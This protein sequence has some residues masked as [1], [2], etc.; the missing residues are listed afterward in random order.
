VSEAIARARALVERGRCRG[1]YARNQAGGE[2]LILDDAA[3]LFCPE[4]A[5]FRVLGMPPSE[6]AE[7]LR[8]QALEDLRRATGMDLP[9]H[10]FSDNP[11][12]SLSDVLYVMRQ[13]EGLA[14]ARE[15]KR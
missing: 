11:A 12:R 1:A 2:V 4:G 14:R 3:A 6:E 9:I 10:E 7:N 5:L 8:L 15:A 13:A